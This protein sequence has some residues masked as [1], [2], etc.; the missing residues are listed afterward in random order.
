MECVF[1]T[2]C[3]SIFKQVVSKWWSRLFS[4]QMPWFFSSGFF[5][6]WSCEEACVRPA[7]QLCN[8]PGGM[9]IHRC[10]YDPWN[11]WCFW[12][13]SAIHVASLLYVHTYQRPQ[14]RILPV[15]FLRHSFYIFFVCN[16]EFYT[17]LCVMILLSL[18]LFITL[19][20]RFCP[21]FFMELWLLTMFWNSPP[22]LYSVFGDTLCML[23]K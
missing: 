3:A 2:I 13:C 5:S 17:T 11:S 15:T 7:S 20:L 16:K 6:L 19:I 14:F 18:H 12:L 10:Y 9:N 1:V 23:A 8:G 22:N 21:C 4:F